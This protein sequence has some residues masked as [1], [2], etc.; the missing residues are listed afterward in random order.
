MPVTYTIEREARLVSLTA[1]GP[2]SVED[3]LDVYARLREDPYFEP[4]FDQLFD[5]RDATP[6]NIYSKQVDM[7]LDSNPFSLTSRRAYVQAPG[8]GFGMGRVAEAFAE[9]KNLRLRSFL[10]MAEARRW[11]L[12]A[13]RD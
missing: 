9:G 3:L 8:V 10:D 6:T 5:F 13:E 7:L 12:A 2:T 4:G 11:V 1:S